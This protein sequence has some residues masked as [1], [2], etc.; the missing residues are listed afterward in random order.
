M[1]GISTS[2]WLI[3]MVN[4]GKYTILVK[5]FGKVNYSWCLFVYAM[6]NTQ[7][8]TNHDIGSP[9]PVSVFLSP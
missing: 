7:Y 6:N 5:H 2:I 4:A 8:A 3:Y 9:I 1:Y